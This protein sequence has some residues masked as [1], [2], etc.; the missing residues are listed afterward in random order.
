[1]RADGPN[2]QH[3]PRA[4]DD[5]PAAGAVWLWHAVLPSERAYG[6]R[7]LGLEA[8]ARVSGCP[9]PYRA[10]RPAPLAHHQLVPAPHLVVFHVEHA[11]PNP[12]ER[13]AGPSIHR[14]GPAMNNG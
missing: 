6:F 9:S 12:P 1:M 2:T 4:D 8:R 3:R 5:V 7:A 13:P 10:L 14:T 11:P